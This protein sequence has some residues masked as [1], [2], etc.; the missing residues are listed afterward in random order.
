M[1]GVGDGYVGLGPRCTVDGRGLRCWVLGLGLGFGVGSRTCIVVIWRGGLVRE[2][3]AEW[4]PRS[5]FKGD[6]GV[7][8][9]VVVGWAWFLGF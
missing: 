2:G 7:G 5:V 1:G 3:G 6:R 9:N 8:W 4:N